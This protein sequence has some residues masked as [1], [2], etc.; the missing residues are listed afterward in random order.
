MPLVE[1]SAAV[2]GKTAAT[3]MMPL[4]R[5]LLELQDRQLDALEKLREDVRALVEGPRR[6]A[7]TAL[8][9]A[10]LAEG[11]RRD[12]L[13]EEVS[14]ALREAHSYELAPTAN[15]AETAAEMAVVSGLLDR[16]D[17]PCRWTC[18]AHEDARAAIETEIPSLTAALKM[19]GNPVSRRVD[20]LHGYWNHL[21]N[22]KYQF[23]TSLTD[24]SKYH[25]SVVDPQ[26]WRLAFTRTF[27]E[28]LVLPREKAE[29]VVALRLRERGEAAEFAVL[30]ADIAQRT[31]QGARL[32]ALH[33]LAADAEQYRQMRR[34]LCGDRDLPMERLSVDVSTAY[35]PEIAW[36]VSS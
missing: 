28:G 20:S 30:L 29:G 7:R 17:E 34:H 15:R 3:V 8:E 1:L 33:A 23:W 24:F 2:A 26:L 35:Q 27:E 19:R 14:A 18:R 22:S 4:L 9:D 11:A 25:P 16:P 21:H 5:D 12:R 32:M 36:V 10:L 13:L 31:P 6:R